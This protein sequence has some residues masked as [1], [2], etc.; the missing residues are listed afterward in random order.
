M[1]PEC[2]TI[3]LVY[4]GPGLRLVKALRPARSSVSVHNSRYISIETTN[5]GLKHYRLQDTRYFQKERFL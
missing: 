1:N 5:A 4:H 2:Y 3:L